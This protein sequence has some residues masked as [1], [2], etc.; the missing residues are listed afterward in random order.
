MPSCGYAA[1]I[2]M[3]WYL[4]EADA[5]GNWTLLGFVVRKLDSRIIERIYVCVFL[6]GSSL[7]EPWEK[8][9]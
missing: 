4:A 9:V 7:S 6:W 8:E 1:M 2:M 5:T 3:H